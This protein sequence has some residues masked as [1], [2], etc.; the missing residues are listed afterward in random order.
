LVTIQS[1][2]TVLATGYTPVTFNVTPGIQNT[3][4]VA[5]DQNHVFNHWAN[6]STNPTRT[7]TPT[8]KTTMVAWFSP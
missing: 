2:S 3:V 6:H 5:N 4:T 7:I 8:G 1:G